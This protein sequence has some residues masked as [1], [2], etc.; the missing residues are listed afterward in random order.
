LQFS[1]E[2]GLIIFTQDSDFGHLSVANKQPF[3]GIVFLPPGHLNPFVHLQT[4]QHILNQ[5]IEVFPP[6][7]LV[8][9][10]AN[11]IIR[12]RVRNHI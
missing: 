7:I 4:I 12:I 9:S 2:K 6:F 3:I 10:N 8:A 5:A 1:Y 11:G